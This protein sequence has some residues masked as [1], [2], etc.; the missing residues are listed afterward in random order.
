MERSGVVD[1]RY[2]AINTSSSTSISITYILFPTKL[3]KRQTLEKGSALFKNDIT[4]IVRSQKPVVY[5][6]YFNSFII[7]IF[8]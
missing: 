1:C 3:Q 5:S 7:L 2:L 8:I 4:T 6:R